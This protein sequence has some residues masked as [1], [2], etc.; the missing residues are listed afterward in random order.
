VSAEKETRAGDAPEAPSDGE[1]Q[2]RKAAPE[3]DEPVE[4]GQPKS[5]PRGRSL[6]SL[7]TP[8]DTFV[9]V[10]ASW[11]YPSFARGFPRHP[12]LDPLV[13]AF[14]RGD[15]R[16]V[17]DG[18]AKLAAS[19]TDDRVRQAAR[20]LRE[21]VEPDPTSKLLFL[22]AAG[23]LAFL[24]YWWVTHGGPDGEKAPAPRP[25]ATAHHAE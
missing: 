2:A 16:T 24:T 7:P 3:L 8:L 9:V 15:Y 19:A 4:S 25:T 20:M 1:A 12:E 10:E 21:R 14:A 6:S 23:L 11:G 13:A 18:A 5:A 17:R 22:L